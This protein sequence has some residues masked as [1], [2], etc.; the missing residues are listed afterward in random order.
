[1]HTHLGA[2]TLCQAVVRE[3]NLRCDRPALLHAPSL[4]QVA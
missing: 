1:M 2:C 3:L 4:P